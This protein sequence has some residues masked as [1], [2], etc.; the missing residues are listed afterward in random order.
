VFVNAN[1]SWR[2]TDRDD[3]YLVRGPDGWCEHDSANKKAKWQAEARVIRFDHDGQSF[4]AKIVRARLEAPP[5]RGGWTHE[6]SFLSGRT[7]AVGVVLDEEKKLFSDG[8]TWLDIPYRL[9]EPALLPEVA[10]SSPTPPDCTWRG[11]EDGSM[12]LYSGS[13][14]PEC[15]LA[16]EYER[17]DVLRP[18]DRMIAHLERS[19]GEASGLI[20]DLGCG[21]GPVS[22][23]FARK[24]AVI[25]VDLDP[26]MVACSKLNCP[27]SHFQVANLGGLRQSFSGDWPAA[28]GVWSSFVPAY[29]PGDGLEA[30][31]SDWA[32]LLKP[33]GWLCLIEIDGL[34]SAHSPLGQY[35]SGFESLDRSL[36]GYDA[37]AGK[38]LEA[39]C[40]AC[41]LTL[42]DHSEWLD[43]ELY[44]DGPAGNDQ[45]AAWTA[46]LS[47]PGIR[48]R[49]EEVFGDSADGARA[50][51][52]DCLQCDQ[53]ASQGRVHMVICS[54]Q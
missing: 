19:V 31:I 53:H 32:S 13:R 46:R 52:L 23:R 22:V 49:C 7:G 8:E 50:A 34:F 26:Q 36:A 5:S 43:Q 11:D 38:R 6:L 42:M 24:A 54:K 16:Q 15:A 51:F 25:G 29:F 39:A 21:A 30:A 35:A 44:F 2:R 9:D 37:F 18:W 33:G 14:L 1:G 17:Q 20:Y 12:Y 3:H 41:G 4:A 28:D 47:R 45:V 10:P 27:G 40:A 48:A